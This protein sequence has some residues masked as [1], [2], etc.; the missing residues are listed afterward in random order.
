[1]YLRMILASLACMS[2]AF[3]EV[4]TDIPSQFEGLN[5]FVGVGGS[6]QGD[7]VTY[8]NYK[9]QGPLMPRVKAEVSYLHDK[10]LWVKGMLG[11]LDISLADRIV[12]EQANASTLKIEY[13]WAIGVAGKM[14]FLFNPSTLLS[15]TLG[16][17]YERVRLDLVDNPSVENE[18]VFVRGGVAIAMAVLTQWGLEIGLDAQVSGGEETQV[19]TANKYTQ[20]NWFFNGRVGVVYHRESELG[21]D[22]LTEY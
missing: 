22:F 1:M 20:G 12:F 10:D 3:D 11:F 5:I 19:T 13:P 14:G 18:Y 9:L 16:L 15:A 21:E 2:V 17:G 6:A 8:I 7:Q 4:F